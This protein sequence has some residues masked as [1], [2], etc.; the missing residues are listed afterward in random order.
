MKIFIA[1]QKIRLRSEVAYLQKTS[2]P[3]LTNGTSKKHFIKI[4]FQVGIL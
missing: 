3:G 1:L 4:F 2:A